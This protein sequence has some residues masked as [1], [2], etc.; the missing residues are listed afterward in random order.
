MRTGPTGFTETPG[1]LGKL[2]C[3]GALQSVVGGG[4]S[5]FVGSTNGGVW[6]TRDVNAVQVESAV[7]GAGAVAPRACLRAAALGAGNRCH[8]LLRHG[9][10]CRLASGSATGCGRLRRHHQ[11]GGNV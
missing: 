2:N 3:S 9:G 7:S 8:D 4:G 5:W 11:L 1:R 10:G 6:R